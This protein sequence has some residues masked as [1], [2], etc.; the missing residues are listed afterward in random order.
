MTSSPSAPKVTPG[1]G[2]TLEVR[3]DVPSTLVTE[4]KE[5]VE[6]DSGLSWLR[7]WFMMPTEEEALKE[8]ESKISTRTPPLYNLH[9]TNRHAALYLWETILNHTAHVKSLAGMGEMGVDEAINRIGALLARVIK[10]LFRKLPLSP[11]LCSDLLSFW[12]VSSLV[13]YISSPTLQRKLR[14]QWLT[15]S[16]GQLMNCTWLLWNLRLQVRPPY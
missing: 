12:Q 6:G 3:E 4:G 14:G 8:W 13:L 16:G 9:F 11:C 1:D 7:S 15:Q 2:L 5:R 10:C